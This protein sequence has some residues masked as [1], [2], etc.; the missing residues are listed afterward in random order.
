M[1]PGIFDAQRSLVVVL[2][3]F[4]LTFS[5]RASTNHH[6]HPHSFLNARL[7]SRV[8]DCGSVT[9]KSTLASA[10]PVEAEPPQER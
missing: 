10:K 1:F 9:T 2:L 7:G 3:W 4:C 8:R 5:A 6:V